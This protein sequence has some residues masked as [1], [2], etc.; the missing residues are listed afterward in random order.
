MHDLHRQIA[1]LYAKS[2]DD[3]L[4]GELLAGEPFDV[5]PFHDVPSLIDHCCFAE[6][7]SETIPPTFAVLVYA[8][9]LS[10]RA[11]GL[12]DRLAN[13][14]SQL[15]KRYKRVIVLSDVMDESTVCNYL[16]AGAHHVIPIGD[17]PRLMYA[18]LNASLRDHS[19]KVQDEWSA[20]PEF[21]KSE[22]C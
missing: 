2:P 8:R 17:S 6:V 10:L 3:K 13:E 21:A 20:E 16:A 19:E 12:T 7:S 5:I 15:A 18:R 22:L 9:K 4:L 14:L 1:L 11:A